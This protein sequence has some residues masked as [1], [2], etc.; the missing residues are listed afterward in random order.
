MQLV[1][2][3]P[4]SQVKALHIWYS[5]DLYIHKLIIQDHF[6]STTELVF[7]N[8]RSNT[9]D[10]HSPDTVAEITRL[11]LPPGTEVISQ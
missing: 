3:T 8:I 9:L 4:Q 10:I 5:P 6:D 7:T 1:P 11:D 2:I